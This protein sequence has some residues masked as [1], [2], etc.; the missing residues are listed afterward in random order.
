MPL[1][2]TSSVL[3]RSW[4]E[5]HDIVEGLLKGHATRSDAISCGVYVIKVSF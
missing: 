4:K 2:E 5:R 3:E 1:I